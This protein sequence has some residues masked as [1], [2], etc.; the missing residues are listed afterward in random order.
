MRR[1]ATVLGV[2]IAIPTTGNQAIETAREGA[3]AVTVALFRDLREPLGRYL[4][5][6]GAQQPEIEEMVQEAFLRLHR[7][8]SSGHGGTQNL[9]GWV[10]RVAQNLVHDRRRGWHGRNVDSLEDRPEAALA[11][12]PGASPEE[13]VLHLEKMDR[14]RAAWL[15][16]P[17]QHR[18]CLSLRAEGLRYREIAAVL[19]VSITSVADLVRDS[20][21]QLGGQSAH[22]VRKPRDHD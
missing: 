1:L 14:L 16:L 5:S 6:L 10:F 7:H 13:R 11:S 22:Q 20:L 12:A 3:R 18:R 9:N 21:A 4:A 17:D 19:G 8:L 2:E 15:A